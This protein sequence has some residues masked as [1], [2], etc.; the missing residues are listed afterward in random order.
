MIG[1]PNDSP[2]T[3]ARNIAILLRFLKNAV[4]EW[5]DSADWIN[6]A[7][8]KSAKGKE[9]KFSIVKGKKHI[10]TEFL[11]QLGMV[12]TTVKGNTAE[13]KNWYKGGTLHSATGKEWRL[14]T[15]KSVSYCR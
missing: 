12:I 15:D 13:D 2:A 8:E 7:I 5:K 3:V 10:T 6:K 14:A 1:I 4:P 11:K 9:E